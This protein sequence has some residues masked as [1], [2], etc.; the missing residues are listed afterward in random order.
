L[1]GF[2]TVSK[3]RRSPT[4]DLSAIRRNGVV[5][6]NINRIGEETVWNYEAGLKLDKGILSGSLGVYYQIYDNFQVSIVGPDGRVVTE[7]AGSARNLGAE[8]EIEVRPTQW[9]SV[10]GN[11]GYIRGGIDNKPS[12]G[13]FAGSRFRLQPE[14]QGAA[15]FII[16]A[17]INESTRFFATPSVTYRSRIY[18]ELPNTPLISQKAVTLVNLRAGVSFANDRFEI[19]G[20]ARNLTNENYLLDA[21]NT[22]GSFGVPTFIPAEPRFYGVQVT[23]RF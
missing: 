9:L 4:V 22:G 12:N 20:F 15:G 3:G 16:N 14:F 8:G 13:R 11:V 7:S 5:V 19:A 2:V 21:G 23:G 10:F 18:F 17:L 1:N 6:P